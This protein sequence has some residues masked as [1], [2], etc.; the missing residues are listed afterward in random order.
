MLIASN[1]K[2]TPESKRHQ[3]GRDMEQRTTTSL[4]LLSSASCRRPQ[5][6]QEQRPTKPGTLWFGFYCF[7]SFCN[8]L[9]APTGA[10]V[11]IP[12]MVN[13]ATH[14]SVKLLDRAFHETRHNFV[15]HCIKSN[16]ALYHGSH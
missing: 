9:C 16:R 10:A 6:L 5:R 14:E 12:D 15:V 1:G 4:L 3:G 8:R 7:C 13:L 11:V 2:R